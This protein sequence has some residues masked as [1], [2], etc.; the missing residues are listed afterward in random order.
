MGHAGGE[1]LNSANGRPYF[2][3]SHNYLNIG[4]YY[5]AES[6]QDNKTIDDKISEDING[7]VGT[8][9]TEQ[10]WEVT[11]DMLDLIA[12][13][14]GQAGYEDDFSNGAQKPQSKAGGH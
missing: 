2:K 6:H 12:P 14:E 5:K 13:T 3:D 10:W 8:S 9:Q 1:S 7:C 4:Y 11:E